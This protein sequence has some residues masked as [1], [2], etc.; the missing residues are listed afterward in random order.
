VVGAS[1][2]GKDTLIAGAR[3]ALSGNRQFV[4][5]IRF[6]TRGGE[7]GGEVHM[8]LDQSEFD[9]LAEGGFFALH[10]E[11]HGLKYGVPSSIGDDLARGR[12]VIVNVS[13]KIV[14]AAAA[15]FA[16]IHVMRVTAPPPILAERL[17]ARGREP[18][19]QIA[20]RLASAEEEVPASIS[21]VLID[22]SGAIA[23]G[24]RAFL[25]AIEAHLR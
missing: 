14:A 8:P 21:H 22:N 2:A 1:G 7:A 11:A 18:P 24:V 17:R 25:A 20:S 12:H 6:I 13:R 3:A 5:P 23:D 10:W 4:F 15:S 9:Q 16:R 19:D